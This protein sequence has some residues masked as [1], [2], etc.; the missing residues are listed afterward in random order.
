MNWVSVSGII[1]L[2]VLVG[3]AIFYLVTAL[4]YKDYIDNKV[5]FKG[6]SG[7]LGQSIQLECP[8]DKKI[9]I[10]SANTLCV[11][12][13]Y[14]DC[15]PF[16][17]GGQINRSTTLDIK[18]NIQS[19]VDTCSNSCTIVLPRNVPTCTGCDKF[20]IVGTYSCV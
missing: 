13:N 14:G 9:S 12:K 15:D 3:I 20:G 8:V 2:V 5:S 16:I 19:Q 17:V 18:Q 4:K 10:T 6:F 11:S 1:I 7:D